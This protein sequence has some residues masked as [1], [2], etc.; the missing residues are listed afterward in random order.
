MSR[1]I[2]EYFSALLT[3]RKQATANHTITKKQI[4]PMKWMSLEVDS[5]PVDPPDEHSALSNTL[6]ETCRGPSKAM[7]G[8]PKHRNCEIT[9]VFCFR[10]VSDNLLHS[11]GKLTQK[12]FVF[13]IILVLRSFTQLSSFFITTLKTLTGWSHDHGLNLLFFSQFQCHH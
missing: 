8:L 13:L 4:L 6:S 12:C 7:P 2:L 1:L 10:P 11:S 5:S 9:N 3:L